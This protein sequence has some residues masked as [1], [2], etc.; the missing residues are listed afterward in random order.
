[1][2]CRIPS[3]LVL[4]LALLFNIHSAISL[5]FFSFSAHYSIRHDGLNAVTLTGS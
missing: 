5:N 1:M 2:K 3:L 4:L